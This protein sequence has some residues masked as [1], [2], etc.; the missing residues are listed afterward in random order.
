MFF[1]AKAEL[2]AERERAI[3]LQPFTASPPSQ[4]AG[5]AQGD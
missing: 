4:A 2:D 1:A 5:S 3:S